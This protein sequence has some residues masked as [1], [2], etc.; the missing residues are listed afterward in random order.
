MILMLESDFFVDLKNYVFNLFKTSLPD[1]AVY[2]NFNHTVQVVEA[3]LEIAT[4]EKIKEGDIEKLLVAA[5]FHDTGFVHGFENHEVKSVEIATDYLKNI[6]KPED[7]IKSVNDIISATIMPQQPKDRLQE[8]ICDADLW[9]LGS[10]KFSKKTNLLRSEYEILCNNTM[11]DEAWLEK[12][13]NFLSTHHYFTDYAYATLNEQKTLN[14]LKVQ[15][16]LKKLKEKLAADALKN[17]LKSEDVKRKKRKEERPDRGIETMFRVTLRNHIKLSDIADTKANILLS[18]S[19]IMLSVAISA[20][21][22]KLDK[23]D[24]EYLI[25]PTLL[26]IISAVVTMIISI[27]STR[28]KVTSGIFTQEDVKSKKVNLLFF[29]NFHKMPLLEFQNGVSEMMNDRDYLYKSLMKDLYFLGI[30]L[31][32][33]YKLLR[34]AYNFFMIGIIISV[35]AFIISF[36]IMRVSTGAV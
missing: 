3:S 13:S 24:N 34:V 1:G 25:F 27:L 31:N 6:G 23:A 16:D 32:K 18:V 26:F 22:P 19:A 29:G 10:D 28:P 17:K 2:H 15:K 12:N 8:I 5:W 20:L 9:H 36:R 30:V 7:Y 33:K 14:I 21:L 11:T 35:I 4:A